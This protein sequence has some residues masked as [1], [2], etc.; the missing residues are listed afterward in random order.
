MTDLL[1]YAFEFMEVYRKDWA[2]L[3]KEFEKNL[4]SDID[5]ALFKVRKLTEM[6]V[7]EIYAN[8]EMEY[9]SFANQA[10]RLLILKNDGVLDE[11]LFKS[12]DRIRRMG[13]SAAHRNEPISIVDGINVHKNLYMI[14]RWYVE[15]YISYDSKIPDYQDPKPEDLSD[16]VKQMLKEMLPNHLNSF[17]SSETPQVSANIL[18]KEEEL[19]TTQG[20]SLLHQLSKLR[21]SSQ[22]AVEGHTGLSEFKQYL[23][24]SRPVESVLESYLKETAETPESTL[25]FLCGSVGDGK[26]H[27]L[28]YLSTTMPDVLGKFE[29]H[30]DATESFDPKR[31]SLDT[32]AEV[33]RPFSD[34][35]INQSNQKLILA[36]NLGV[37]HNF[38]E[39][40]YVLEDYRILKEYVDKANVFDSDSITKIVEH[41]HFRLVNF[42]DYNMFELTENGPVSAYMSKLFAKITDSVSENPFY[43]A[44]QRDKEVF[45]NNTLLLN[46]EMFSS[47]SVREQ[48]IQ[49]IIKTIIKDKIILSSRILLNY[50]YDI[51]VPGT[52]EEIMTSDFIDMLPNLLPNLVFEG[53]DKS[54]FLKMMAHQDPIHYRS[55]EI[56][57][58]LVSLH[59]SGN[60]YMAYRSAIY[61]NDAQEWIKYLENLD[62]IVYL[63]RD[64]QREMSELFIRACYLYQSKYRDSF[65]DE[66]FLN[67]VK[68]LYAYNTGQKRLLQN[69]YYDIDKAIFLWKGTPK[70]NYLYIDDEG[71][72]FRIA[73]R[74]QLKN[75]AIALQD[76][77]ERIIERFT[78]SLI[79]GFRCE[80]FKEV[81]HIEIDLP[82]YELI[83]RVT[84]G[85]RLNKKDRDDSI[86]FMEF[87][88]SLLPYGRQTEEILIRDTENGLTFL[89]EYDSDFET[90]SFSREL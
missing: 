71:H 29:I 49:L 63:D 81:H 41:P 89:L 28:S 30:N 76:N 12:F 77:S 83:V 7:K 59:N 67:Y 11:E 32:L 60:Y 2:D 85:Y 13:N 51:L 55:K 46:Y 50:I 6:I 5:S 57:D 23:H 25:I 68:F 69:L 56:D 75:A 18:V 1:S 14:L 62:D 17:V 38:L 53:F 72:A 42:G 45:K 15:A 43:L 90:Y 47:D 27:L 20:S 54:S 70:T 10:E 26:S 80:P 8:E 34:T 61:D 16:T 48:I 3:A 35:Q 33:L 65:I 84:N 88:E 4:F 24:V 39:S 31:N 58:S 9:P 78:T 19:P 79:L 37:L 66:V 21:E 82:L 87:I 64:T 86:K 44:Y 73:E 22:D 36:I 74:I 52:I 40:D